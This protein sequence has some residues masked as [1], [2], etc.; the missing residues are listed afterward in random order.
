MSTW[1]ANTANTA[2]SL[3][4]DALCGLAAL[5]KASIHHG[6]GGGVVWRLPPRS[7]PA[8]QHAHH[9]YRNDGGRHSNEGTRPR[10]LGF[11]VV[12]LRMLPSGS[13]D[14]EGSEGMD[15][16]ARG[17]R[18]QVTWYKAALQ[19]KGKTKCNFH[20]QELLRSKERERDGF[21]NLDQT[22][23]PLCESP[24]KS[25]PSVEPTAQEEPLKRPRRLKFAC[26]RADCLAAGQWL[27]GAGW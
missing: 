2:G 14:T 3:S 10:R 4:I 1:F 12:Q 26:L 27:V 23:P 8:R 11:V 13:I 21:H 5:R 9:V 17:H 19:W 16:M 25:R 15:G 18:R 22:I 20:S 7:Q 6:G 24:H